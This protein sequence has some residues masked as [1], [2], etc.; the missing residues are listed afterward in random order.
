[1]LWVSSGSRCTASAWV[2]APS[3]HTKSVHPSG[4]TSGIAAAVS[5]PGFHTT[6][7]PEFFFRIRSTRPSTGSTTATSPVERYTRSVSPSNRRSPSWT[8]SSRSR[9]L[10]R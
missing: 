1:M 3:T 4:P 5:A 6:V 10:S 2:L 9:T 8:Q 7:V